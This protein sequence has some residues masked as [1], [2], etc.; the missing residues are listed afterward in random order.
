M[1]WT[2]IID[3]ATLTGYVREALYDI[4]A[5]NGALSRWLPNRPVPG[6]NVRFVAGQAGLVPEASYRAYDAEPAVGRKPGGRRTTLELPPIGQNVPVS[7]YDQLRIRNAADDVVLAEILS[8]ARQVVRAVA[9]RIERLRGVVLSTGVA[10][11]PETG[12]ADAFGR[13]PSHTVTAATLWST[14]PSVSRLEDLQAWCDL[15]ETTNGVLPGVILASRRVVRV[16]AQG[17]ELAL[18]LVGG[19]SRPAT[20]ADVAAILAGAGLPPVEVYTRRTASGPVLPDTDLLLLPA[21][22]AV[23]DWEGTELGGSFWGQT[24]S[25]SEPGWGIEDAEQPGI[26]AG[27][28]RNDKPPM[29]AEVISDAIA[30]PVLANANLSLRATVLS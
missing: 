11:I 18:S 3:P 24:L 15:Y 1:L 20:E 23:D 14:G 29:V 19:A 10:T 27:V 13:D 25:A 16:L 30:M 9:D 17:S 2:D 4:E 21:P 7:E 8:T 22:V 26:V 28:Y 12:A 5:R 6:I